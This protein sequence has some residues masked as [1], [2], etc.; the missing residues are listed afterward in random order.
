MI[1]KADVDEG[2]MVKDSN[3]NVVMKANVLVINII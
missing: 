1:T 3:K 2:V